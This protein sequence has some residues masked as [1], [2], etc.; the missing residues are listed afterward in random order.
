MR[1]LWIVLVVSV[2]GCHNPVAPPM[3]MA[4]ASIAATTTFFATQHFC[5]DDGLCVNW[6]ADCRNRTCAFTNLSTS[7]QPLTTSYWQNSCFRDSD[8]FS[9]TVRYPDCNPAGPD[10]ITVTLFQQDAITQT[11]AQGVVVLP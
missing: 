2:L 6:R 8:K 5:A 3:R 4:E 1:S 9:F 10:T 7:P 11:Y